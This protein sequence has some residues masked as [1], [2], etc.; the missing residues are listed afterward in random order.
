MAASPRSV[1]SAAT[2][3]IQPSDE[4]VRVSGTTGISNIKVAGSGA[5]GGAGQR[6]TRVFDGILT[7]TDGGNLVMAGNLTTSADDTLELIYDDAQQKW[8]ELGRS[9]N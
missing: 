9:A 5:G 7:V 2:L 1:A 3:E 4:F 8:Y 6:L